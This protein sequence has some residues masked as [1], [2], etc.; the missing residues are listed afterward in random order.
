MK[1]SEAFQS[2]KVK[3]GSYLRLAFHNSLILVA[4]SHEEYHT[5]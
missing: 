2:Q 5:L 3:Q 1:R 4:I